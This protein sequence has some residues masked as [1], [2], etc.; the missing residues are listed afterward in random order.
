MKTRMFR[1]KRSKLKHM[2]DV[3]FDRLGSLRLKKSLLVRDIV[4]DPGEFSLKSL[5]T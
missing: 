2:E 5:S 3:L 4:D 1:T